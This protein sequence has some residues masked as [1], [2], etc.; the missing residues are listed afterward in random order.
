LY[1]NKSLNRK[2]NKDTRGL[3]RL[4]KVTVDVGTVVDN[5]HI[6]INNV[7]RSIQHAITARKMDI[8]KRCVG[9]CAGISIQSKPSIWKVTMTRTAIAME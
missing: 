5:F 9:A 3:A 6:E 7:Q 1:R 8:L 2:P 4:T